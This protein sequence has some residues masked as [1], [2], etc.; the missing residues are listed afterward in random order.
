[1]VFG[2]CY[3]IDELH[4]WLSKK[5]N[6]VPFEL[7]REISTQRKQKSCILGTCQVFGRVPKEIREQAE[8]VYLPRTFFNCL[9]IVRKKLDQRNIIPIRINLSVIMVLSFLFMIKSLE[10]HMIRLSE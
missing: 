2:T 3:G 10:S 5:S 1:M 4:T 8:W 9:T 6:Q 7:L